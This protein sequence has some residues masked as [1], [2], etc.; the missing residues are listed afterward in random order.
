MFENETN[1]K[2]DTLN[3]RTSALSDVVLGFLHN[4]CKMYHVNRLH[5]QSRPPVIGYAQ[6]QKHVCETP[7]TIENTYF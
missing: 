7:T 1:R 4:L 3:V 6:M 2:S 5:P